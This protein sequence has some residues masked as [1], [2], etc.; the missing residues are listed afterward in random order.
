MT[1]LVFD[2]ARITIKGD[3]IDVILHS[4]GK[5]TLVPNGPISLEFHDAS[6]SHDS[7]L[8]NAMVH[9]QLDSSKQSLTAAEDLTFAKR[10][11]QSHSLHRRPGMAAHEYLRMILDTAG[12]PLKVSDLLDLLPFTAYKGRARSRSNMANS[13][14]SALVRRKEIFIKLPDASWGLVGRDEGLSEATH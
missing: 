12:S 8:A 14:R 11:A 10:L 3:F 1:R 5:W 2:G 9:G 7:S 6:D 13:I 4:A